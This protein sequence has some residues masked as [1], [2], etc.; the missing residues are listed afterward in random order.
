[1]QDL[2]GDLGLSVHYLSEVLNS[3]LKQNFSDLINSYRIKEAIKM[4]KDPNY[5]NEKI[6]NIA[7]DS[8]FNNKA[9]FNNAFK[10]YTGMT[11]GKYKAQNK[12]VVRLK[13]TA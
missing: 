4:L 11:P 13:S 12:R 1:M 2:A 3:R 9:S 8:G 7:Y 6:I 10:K 5:E